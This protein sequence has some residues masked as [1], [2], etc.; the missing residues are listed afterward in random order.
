LY[1]NLIPLA[2]WLVLVLIGLRT[3][4]QTKELIGPGLAILAIATVVAWIVL[5]Y[6]GLFQNALMREELAEILDAE[7]D[8]PPGSVFVGFSTPKYTGLLDAHEDVGFLCFT[9]SAII[10]AGEQRT[11]ELPRSSILRI[12]YRANV[13]SV[14]GLGRWISIEALANGSPVRMLVE[15][16]ERNSMLGNLRLST[17]LVRSIETWVKTGVFNRPKS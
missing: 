8:L 4:L 11:V 9:P 14:L 7:T 10:F 12:R 16:R 1:G 5:N 15:P 2:F 13:H 3:I 17:K 6:T